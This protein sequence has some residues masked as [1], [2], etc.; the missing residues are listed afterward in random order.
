M[1]WVANF[2]FKEINAESTQ[3][4]ILQGV[5]LT[6]KDRVCVENSQGDGI[7]ANLC[8]VPKSTMV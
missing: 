3:A 7:V 1:F 6:V 4:S 2:L 8:L 5:K